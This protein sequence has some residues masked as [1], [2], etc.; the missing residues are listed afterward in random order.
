VNDAT[1]SKDELG[2]VALPHPSDGIR[3]PVAHANK[4]LMIKSDDTGPQR[5]LPPR[6]ASGSDPC[7][8]YGADVRIQV[9]WRR[10]EIANMTALIAARALKNVQDS[11]A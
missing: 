3:Q 5:P 10:L 8:H 7:A 6:S 2:W 9:R 1:R 4:T 11:V